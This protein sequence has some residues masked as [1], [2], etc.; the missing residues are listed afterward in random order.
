LTTD[1]EGSGRL[2][3]SIA[4]NFKLRVTEKSSQTDGWNTNNER[5]QTSKI[6]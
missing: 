2:G 4:Y 1:D 5:Y 6:L 3:E